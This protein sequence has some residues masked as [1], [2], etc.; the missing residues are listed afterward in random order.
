MNQDIIS[1]DDAHPFMIYRNSAAGRWN[2][3]AKLDRQLT[4]ALNHNLIWAIRPALTAL[5]L[6]LR[7]QGQSNRFPSRLLNSHEFGSSLPRAIA[8]LVLERLQ[9]SRPV[10][11]QASCD[12]GVLRLWKTTNQQLALLG[13]ETAR[14]AFAIQVLPRLSR[15]LSEDSREAVSNVESRTFIPAVTLRR[16]VSQAAAM[17]ESIRKAIERVSPKVVATASAELAFSRL[18]VSAC[19]E[20]GI[21][22]VYVP[23]APTA[24]NRIYADI[25]HDYAALRG[26]ADANY[27]ASLGARTAQISVVGDQSFE[28]FPIRP[29]GKTPV[30]LFAT[31]LGPTDRLQECIQAVQGASIRPFVRI[32][33]APHPRGRARAL[34]VAKKFA[35][36]V[37]PKGV[38]TAQ[39][40]TQLNV[41]L[42]ITE[43]SSGV[44]LELLAHGVPVQSLSS[45]PA[46]LFEEKL[47][48]KRTTSSELVATIEQNIAESGKH[49]Q[50]SL[51]VTQF[52]AAAGKKASHALRE[53]IAEPLE[54][55]RD[56]VL[57]SWHWK[58]RSV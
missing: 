2:E 51:N 33:L 45:Q 35:V 46:Y 44:A 27:Y 43:H 11:V 47:N 30:L 36:E 3:D 15:A 4:D 38:R 14:G 12:E 28:V 20:L 53:A 39:A 8:S 34:R 9:I 49:P 41:T 25:P 19:R 52:L 40:L 7:S 22:T 13:R 21:P 10:S 24:R 37:V 42:A 57:D 5:H 26:V 1:P 18:A 16:F 50:S 17:R 55:K 32:V 6:A 29:Q 54:P 31:G 48:V 23:H 58:T 56:G